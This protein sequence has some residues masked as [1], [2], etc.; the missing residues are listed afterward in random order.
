MKKLL[1]ILLMI[2]G[3]ILLLVGAVIA[4]LMF[5]FAPSKVE[6][7]SALSPDKGIVAT[8]TEINGGATTSF[9]YVIKVQNKNQILSFSKDVANL[10]GAGRSDC[11]YGV[12]L[13]W[14]SNEVLLIKYLDAKNADL[15][16][17]KVKVGGRMITV[18]LV[19]G[20]TNASAPCGGMEYN[21]KK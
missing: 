2:F 4:G 5:L 21:L 7:G 20:I 6:V 18:K 14:E 8:I 15:F 1:K 16:S 9:G 11:A 3:G 17:E 12:D 10:Y 13:E 19:S